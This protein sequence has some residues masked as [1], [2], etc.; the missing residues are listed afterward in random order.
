MNCLMGLQSRGS[1]I[2]LGGA[3]QRMKGSGG[4]IPAS[5]RKKRAMLRVAEQ[6]TQRGCRI[7]IPEYI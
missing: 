5:H 3:Q 2:L 1:Q 6:L 4:E 7:S